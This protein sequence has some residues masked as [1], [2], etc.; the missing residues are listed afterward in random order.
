MNVVQVAAGRQGGTRQNFPVKA[1]PKG[2]A[3]GIARVI[4]CVG[5]HNTFAK[6]ASGLGV[7]IPPRTIAVLKGAPI[8]HHVKYPVVV[9]PASGAF[10]GVVCTSRTTLKDVTRKIRED[11][12]LQEHLQGFDFYL[13]RANH[14]DIPTV[15]RRMEDGT[16]GAASD[17][18]TRRVLG[19]CRTLVGALTSLDVPVFELTVAVRQETVY[20]I[21]CRPAYVETH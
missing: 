14:G 6:W 21:S 13:L 4:A 2:S 12:Q 9:K 17:N 16:E 1:R 5:N 15:K 11:W 7:P 19:T 3:E 10:P 20:V 8:P 18:V